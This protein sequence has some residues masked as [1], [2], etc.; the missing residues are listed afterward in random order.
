MK[1][2]SPAVSAGLFCC[3]FR[4]NLTRKDHGFGDYRV[5]HDQAVRIDAGCQRSGLEWNS[6]TAIGQDTVHE[7]RYFLTPA[8]ENVQCNFP[9]FLIQRKICGL[10][11]YFISEFD[12]PSVG[13]I[14]ILP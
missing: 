14:G 11:S 5:I 9:S 1:M 6:V 10:F 8:V 4:R 12:L 13:N 7:C 3:P 2:K